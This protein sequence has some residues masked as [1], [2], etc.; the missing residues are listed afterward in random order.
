MNIPIAKPLLDELEVDAV[1]KVLRS[2]ALAQ[3]AVVAEF[4]KKFAEFVGTK[5]AI[6]VAN[7]T[8][9]LELALLA[10]G[11]GSGDEVITT[12]FTFIATASSIS[13]VGA[14]PVFVDIEPSTFNIDPRKIEA[15]ITSKTKAIL[16]V[17][18][19]GL[20]ADMVEINRIARQHGL[21]VLEDA[22]Q[23]HGSSINGVMAGALGDAATFSFYPTKNM[24][25]SEGGIITTSD[26]GIAELARMIRN[27]GQRVRY[28]HE[29]IASN[30]RMTEVE[31]AIG[32]VQ[33]DKLPLFNNRRQENAERY[34]EHIKRQDIHLPRVPTGYRH[35]YHQFTLRILGSLGFSRDDVA[36]RLNEA[37]IGTGVHYPIPIHLQKPYADSNARIIRNAERAA[38]QVLSIPVHP[39]LTEDELKFIVDTINSL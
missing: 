11:I 23:A 17:H 24:T 8:L 27:Q 4:E 16:P 37:G 35:A 13:R 33:L 18:L 6:A 5:H 19:Y 9:A 34:Y 15:A 20:A 3:G 12:P 1:S 31:A 25:T 21:L 36:K 28:E 2:G 10:M 22:A 38:K 29:L 30:F 14:I 32:L 26:D 39:A 7:G